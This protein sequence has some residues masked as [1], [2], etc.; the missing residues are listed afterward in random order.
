MQFLATAD[1]QLKAYQDAVRQYRILMTEGDVGDPVVA[2]PSLPTYGT[3][4][5]VPRG[6]FERLDSIVKRARVTPAYTEEIGALLGIIPVTPSRPLPE[7]LK[8]AI[9]ASPSLG[10]YTFDL[11]V[12]R[13]GMTAF[14]VQIQ[15]SG[16]STWQD[17]AYTT[18]NPAVVTVTPTTPGDPE[19][20]LV[21]AWLMDKQ[22]PVGIPSDPTFVTVNP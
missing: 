8:P 4:T 11:N 14:K 15:R 12:T 21:R 9:V 18:G 6:L 2:F 7:D 13:M 20:I 1:T 5:G 10:G 19:R 17:V 16:A 22:T 3:P